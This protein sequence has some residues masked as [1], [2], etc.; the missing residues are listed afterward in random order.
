MT[1]T[2]HS[3]IATFWRY[4]SSS[5]DRLVALALETDD[6]G[7]KWEPPAPET[8]SILTLAFHTLGN[9]EENILGTLCGRPV[10]RDR[11]SEFTTRERGKDDLSERWGTLRPQL[12]GSLADLGASALDE[13]CYH[14]RRGEISGRDVLI[15][16][17]RHSAEH[18]GQ[19]ELTRDLW[20]AQRSASQTEL[21]RTAPDA[22]TRRDQRST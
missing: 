18:L 13:S 5:V 12:E 17:A 7:L 2:P 3:E 9:A 8:N 11:A 6:E 21:E 4:I 22:I 16:V 15:V 1:I 14:P 20:L 10:K 19:A